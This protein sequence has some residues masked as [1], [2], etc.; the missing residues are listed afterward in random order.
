MVSL[1]DEEK[2]I[3]RYLSIDPD[4]AASRNDIT[5]Y[6]SSSG[7]NPV[8][9]QDLKDKLDNLMD[10]GYI[11][12]KTEKL[13]RSRV[14]KFYLSKALLGGKSKQKKLHGRGGIIQD[15]SKLVKRLFGSIFLLFGLGFFIH[16]LNIT[17]SSISSS[18]NFNP[19]FIP[20]LAL[21]IIGLA[22]LKRSFN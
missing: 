21:A 8:S 2:G 10:Y 22:L 17:G 13:G 18:G 6:L 3:L 11:R 9:P 15:T 7:Y 1:D 12:A 20:T 16:S 14:E 19:V 4:E 5:K